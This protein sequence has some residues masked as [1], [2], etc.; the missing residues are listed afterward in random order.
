MEFWSNLFSSKDKEKQENKVLEKLEKEILPFLDKNH[1]G[2]LV[3]LETLISKYPKT[4]S[5]VLRNK[6]ET[7]D[8]TTILKIVRLFAK[9]KKAQKLVFFLENCHPKDKKDRV[10]IFLISLLLLPCDPKVYQSIQ[11]KFHDI[12]GTKT[13]QTLCELI[14]GSEPENPSYITLMKGVLGLPLL[15]V[16]KKLTQH[17]KAEIA[18][19]SLLALACIEEEKEEIFLIFMESLASS[20]PDISKGAALAFSM[21]GEISIPYLKEALASPKLRLRTSAAWALGKM[22]EKAQKATLELLNALEDDDSRVRKAAQWALE[23]I[24]ASILP[25]LLKKL[26]STQKTFLLRSGCELLEKFPLAESQE[27]MIALANHPDKEIKKK[28]FQIL[29]KNKVLESSTIFIKA[30]Q[31]QEEIQ[32]EALQALESLSCFIP[33]AIDP[34]IA[35]LKKGELSLRKAAGNAL[36]QI[37]GKEE[38]AKEAFL[39][40]LK[41]SE[42]SIKKAALRGLALFKAEAYSALPDILNIL[43]TSTEKSLLLHCMETLAQIGEKAKDAIPLLGNWVLSKDEPLSIKATKAL[44]HIGLEATVV[45]FQKAQDAN[46][47][48]RREITKA[49]V[50][51]GVPVIPYLVKAIKSDSGIFREVA[52]DALGYLGEN[53]LHDLRK[54][55]QEQDFWIKKAV[56]RAWQKAGKVAIPY[57]VD[58]IREQEDFNASVMAIEILKKMK[59]KALSNMITLLDD[60]QPQLSQLAI[61]ILRKVNQEYKEAIPD[62]IALIGNPKPLIRQSVAW[63]LGEIGNQDSIVMDAIS[64]LEQDSDATVNRI[65]KESR[66]KLMIPEEA[67]KHSK[68]QI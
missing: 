20:N 4:F 62:L 14:A 30:L 17:P 10:W 57:L 67:G 66:Q 12:L 19:S 43:E 11:K 31:E 1:D 55:M 58:I 40:A 42:K 59:Y 54:L 34:V 3:V 26:K 51:I 65:A 47:K 50:K 18:Q 15:P 9:I 22:G 23:K 7:W 49:L 61:Q 8:Y 41:D 28:A 16:L 37:C 24:G 32:K 52:S 53:S 13:A 38:K 27:F 46:N 21:Q 29:G 63:C 36:F 5:L 25:D 60:P 45:L 48:Q 39:Y 33:E 68:E 6:I 35:I 2:V 44:G 64:I 56:I